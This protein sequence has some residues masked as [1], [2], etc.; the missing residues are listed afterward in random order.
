MDTQIVLYDGFDPLDVVAP[1][2]VLTAGSDAAGGGPRVELVSAEG[3]RDVVSGNRGLTLRATSVLDPDRPGFVVVP[4]V[5]GP[6]AGDPDAGVATIP[7]LLAR[8][9]TTAAVPL[10]RRALDNP[11]VTVAT[12]CGGSLALAMAGLLE[13]RYAVTHAQGMDMLEATGVNAVPARVV[14]DG[15]LIS[16]GGVTSG[17]DLAFHLLDHAYG[18][19]IAHAVELLFQYDRRGT[20]WANTGRTPVEV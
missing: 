5:C 7:V 11:E 17:L 14:D 9:G 10:M 16:G 1:Y 12:V 19:R 8:F 4:G 6:V 3:A 2:E 13:G 18:P 20:V 15:D